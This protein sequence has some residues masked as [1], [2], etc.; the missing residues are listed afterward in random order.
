MLD[1]MKGVAEGLLFSGGMVTVFKTF[2][3]QAGTPGLGLF[4]IP[5]A[6]IFVGI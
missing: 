5:P 4:A 3:V 2:Q 1:S 6:V